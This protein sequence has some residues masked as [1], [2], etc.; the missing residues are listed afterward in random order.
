MLIFIAAAAPIPLNKPHPAQDNTNPRKF[1][2]T[3][4]PMA[5]VMAAS[6]ST[7]EYCSAR[8][9]L[10]RSTKPPHANRAIKPTK[11][12]AAAS[13]S[14]CP[15]SVSASGAEKACAKAPSVQPPMTAAI[16][17]KKIGRIRSAVLKLAS[18]NPSAGL[19]GN[20][21]FR[22]KDK[23]RAASRQQPCP[24]IGSA[25]AAAF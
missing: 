10:P 6:I 9:A 2:Q 3:N 16:N 11:T 7:S 1:W 8:S 20:E 24:A 15:R 17:G 21:L 25:T 5:K 4:A 14:S 22:R 19:V 23:W 18:A 13:R 12:T